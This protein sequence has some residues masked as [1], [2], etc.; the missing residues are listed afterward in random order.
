MKTKLLLT[1][2]AGL[3]LSLNLP[4]QTGET[5]TLTDKGLE[6]GGYGA[7][8]MSFTSFDGKGLPMFGMRGGW[9]INHTFALGLEGNFYMPMA[10]YDLKDDLGVELA[11]V[12]I[13][14]GH[15]GFL[16]EPVIFN[17]KIVHINFPFSIGLGWM[18]YLKDWDGQP[19]Y[20]G[21]IIDSNSF[22]YWK[23]AIGGEVNVSS[24]FRINLVVSY[25]FAYDLHL[26][27]TENDAFD[28]WNVSLVFKF[29]KF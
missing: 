4:A 12:R 11:K 22:W 23:P 6:S 8:V 7:P 10:S 25:R 3:L 19:N 5:Q 28:G 17:D 29:G 15:G 16:L 2:L 9:I 26:I 13:V 14:G 24:F 21:E 20:E 27:A 1:T 18:G